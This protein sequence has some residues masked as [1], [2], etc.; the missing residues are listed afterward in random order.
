MLAKA[1]AAAGGAAAPA[2]AVAEALRGYERERVGRAMPVTVK[3]HVMGAM[4]QIRNPWVSHPSPS[5]A[6]PLMDFAHAQSE[7]QFSLEVFAPV[8]QHDVEGD[9]RILQD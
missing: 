9:H 7:A 5:D 8:L 2:A 1:L 3:S 6:L 4:L